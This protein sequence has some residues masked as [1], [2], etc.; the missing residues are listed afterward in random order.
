M[1]P[2]G[3]HA[4]ARAITTARTGDNRHARTTSNYIDLPRYLS[5]G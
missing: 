2:A 4:R 3:K 5:F 1:V